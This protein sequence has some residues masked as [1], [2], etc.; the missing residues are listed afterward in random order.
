MKL[1]KHNQSSFKI[2]ISCVLGCRL[3]VATFVYFYHSLIQKWY[4]NQW[5]PPSVDVIPPPKFCA[6][7]NKWIQGSLLMTWLSNTDLVLA[8]VALCT[9]PAQPWVPPPNPPN[10][11]DSVN[12]PNPNPRSN[13]NK[14]NWDPRIVG[15]EPLAKKICL[16]RFPDIIRDMNAK[17]HPVSKTATGEPHC[18]SWRFR[19]K[20]KLDCYQKANHIHTPPAVINPL[21]KWC[22]IALK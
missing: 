13:V 11:A 2:G 10:P 6:Y 21:I 22:T 17:G 7:L 5:N 20:C 9:Q 1:Y 19:G 15:D 18:F 8:F 12:P 3:R 14:L 16:Y 4:I